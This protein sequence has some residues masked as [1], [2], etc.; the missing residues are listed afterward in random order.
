MIKQIK[1]LIVK[2]NNTIVGYLAEIEPSIIGFQYDDEWIKNGFSIS[3]LSLP[4]DNTVHINKKNIFSGLYGVF[5][6][7]LPDGWGQLLMNRLLLKKGINPDKVSILTKLSLVNQN[8]LGGLTYEPSQP[9]EDNYNN[10]DFDELSKEVNKILN[11]E[12]EHIDLDLIYGLGGSSGGARPKIHIKIDNEE[13]IIKFA[14]SIDP[15]NIGEKEF[16][17][18]EIAQKCGLTVN[19]HRLFPS[20]LCKGYFG[21][22]RFDRKGTKRIHMISLSS[23]LETTHTI[24]NLDYIH[25]FQVIQLISAKPTYDLYEA[26]YRMCFNVF[27]VNKDDHGK[28]FSFLYDEN[29]NGY[30]LSPSYDLTYVNDKFE[31]E[32]TVNGNGNPTKEDLIAVAKK[33]NLSI[34]KCTSIMNSI[35]EICYQHKNSINKS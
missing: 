9:F 15:K 30:V 8:G 18:N 26:F 19:E 16:I 1:K 23:I 13:W 21:V 5:W 32:M 35:E 25:L 29:L 28:N 10:Y 12:N 34:Q 22:K 33:F 14:C 31:H 2:Y 7:S 17:A 20:K 3:P 4:L 27:Y 24:P 11:N 6:D